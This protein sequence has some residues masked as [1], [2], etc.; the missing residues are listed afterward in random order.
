[1]VKQII[2][3]PTIVSQTQLAALKTAIQPGGSTNSV[4]LSLV[5]KTVT[6]PYTVRLLTSTAGTCPTCA[7]AFL[8]AVQTAVAQA[9]G[10]LPQ[11]V[12]CSCS[13]TGT[14]TSTAASATASLLRLQSQGRRRL[15][16]WMRRQVQESDGTPSAPPPQ[17]PS[18]PSSATPTPTGHCPEASF[19][20]RILTNP[21]DDL[22]AIIGKVLTQQPTMPASAA[23][24]I[25]V[26]AAQQVHLSSTLLLQ[27]PATALTAPSTAGSPTAGPSPTD[28]SQLTSRIAKAL[29]VD[30]QAVTVVD[31]TGQ[32][33][34]TPDPNT[35]PGGGGT[36]GTPQPVGG[37]TGGVPAAS[38]GTG[39]SGGA[40]AGI[41]LGLLLG[42]VLLVGGLYYAGVRRRRVSPGWGWEGGPCQVQSRSRQRGLPKRAVQRWRRVSKAEE[43]PCR[44]TSNSRGV[45]G[46]VHI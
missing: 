15:R 10:V 19:V 46:S 42:A 37:T 31:V 8:S 43:P 1:M 45:S 3:V 13:A 23:F 9:L 18:V 30:P 16:W 28:T 2:D 26:P 32:A 36:G 41:V 35:G 34:I 25:P 24:S 6:V 33:I 7:P 39:L 22:N 11:N 44:A 21:F 5:A 29:T 12:Q 17:P 38:G 40:I 27:Q 4:S 14:T 20:A